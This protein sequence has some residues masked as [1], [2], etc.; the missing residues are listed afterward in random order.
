MESFIGDKQLYIDSFGKHHY[1][2]PTMVG[3][4]VGPEL[5]VTKN[6]SVSAVYGFV[7]Y[8]L[9]GNKIW[10]DKINLTLTTRPGAKKNFLLGFSYSFLPAPSGNAKFYGINIGYK[11]F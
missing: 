4:S 7:S 6:V 2:N 3:L 11:I 8:K 10:E 5:S 1:G 9:F